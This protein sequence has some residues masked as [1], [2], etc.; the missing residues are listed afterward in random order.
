VPDRREAYTHKVLDDLAQLRQDVMDAEIDDAL[1]EA[2]EPS[3][4]VNP[5][6]EGQKEDLATFT[7]MCG[8]APAEFNQLRDQLEPALAVPQRG[9][10]RVI[11]AIDSLFLLLHWLRTGNSLKAIA[12]GFNLRQETLQ[13]RMIEVVRLIEAPL[14]ARYLEE[15]GKAPL[16]G[17]EDFPGCGV[18]VDA[19]VQNRAVRPANGP[20]SQGVSP[21]STVSTL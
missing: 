14:T 15:M 11:G 2:D 7:A 16:H 9:R 19:T 5:I 8:I 10:A 18:V 12:A 4:A 17:D 1:L 21:G 3:I 20:T 13:K 6:Y